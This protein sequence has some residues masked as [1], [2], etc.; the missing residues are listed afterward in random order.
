MTSAQAI[1]MESSGAIFCAWEPPVCSAPA[2]RSAMALAADK[3][4][5][6]GTASK[7]VSLIILFLQGR[8]EHDRHVRPQARRS[9]RI[10]RRV[11]ADRHQRRR[12]CKSASTCQESLARWTSSRWSARSGTAIPTTARPI[13]TCS[14]ATRP[15]RASTHDF[16]QQPAPVPRRDHGAQARAARLRAPLCLPAANASQRR[17][18][19][20]LGPACA[21]FTIEADPAALNF[22]VP[23]ILPPLSLDA[24]AAGSPPTI[25]LASRSVSTIGRSAGQRQRPLGEPVPAKGVRPDGFARGQARPSTF[26]PSRPRCA[27]SMAAIRWGNR[28]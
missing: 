28:A 20:Y 14:P 22:S 23:D 6:Q 24:I 3:A 12:A 4:A 16:A 18:S 5:E 10:S 1:A 27:T 11:P 15:V 7:D 8:H 19:A 9:G 17:S 25:A 13:T 26:M 2:S 21:P